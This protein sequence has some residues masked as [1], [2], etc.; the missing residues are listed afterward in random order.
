MYG[1]D[2]TTKQDGF[3][4]RIANGGICQKKTLDGYSINLLIMGLMTLLLIQI[5]RVYI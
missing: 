3:L 1:N 4:G 5:K 2:K